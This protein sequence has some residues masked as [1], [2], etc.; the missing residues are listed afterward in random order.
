MGVTT[1]DSSTTSTKLSNSSVTDEVKVVSSNATS[2]A[3]F[4]TCVDIAEPKVEK[5]VP[6]PPAELR[7][8]RKHK[9]QK[10]PQQPE[11]KNQ[12]LR[13][14]ARPLF[15]INKASNNSNNKMEGYLATLEFSFL[16][17]CQKSRVTFFQP[18]FYTFDKDLSRQ[19]CYLD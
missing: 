1:S 4:V 11:L 12:P 8:H 3:K 15:P 16:V 2:D 18:V 6:V 10:R 13:P 19:S 17:C 9:P 14:Q 7:R 5:K